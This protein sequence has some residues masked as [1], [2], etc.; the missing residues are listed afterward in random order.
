[1]YERAW[2][3]EKH[4]YFCEFHIGRN[5]KTAVFAVGG[6]RTNRNKKPQGNRPLDPE[7]GRQ[8]RRERVKETG[9]GEAAK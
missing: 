4:W 8:R 3:H 7:R 6:R 1:M 2:G 9:K 5:H